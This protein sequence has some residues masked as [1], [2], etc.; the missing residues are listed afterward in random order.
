MDEFVGGALFKIDETTSNVK[1][2]A[3]RPLEALAG[4]IALFKAVRRGVEVYQQ[5]GSLPTQRR[6]RHYPDDEQLFI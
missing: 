5:L 2:I 3:R 6:N 1:E 4:P